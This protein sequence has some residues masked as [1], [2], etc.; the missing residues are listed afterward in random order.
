MITDENA[1]EITGALCSYLTAAFCK[2]ATV[3][4]VEYGLPT[5]Y[6][7]HDGEIVTLSIK[8]PKKASAEA[9]VDTLKSSS[10]TSSTPAIDSLMAVLDDQPSLVAVDVSSE[11]IVGTCANGMKD[12]GEDDIDCGSPLTSSCGPCGARKKCFRDDGCKYGVCNGVA[13]DDNAATCEKDPQL[14]CFD[15][16]FPCGVCC[17]TGMNSYGDPCW[18]DT[19]TA[20][21]CCAVAGPQTGGICAAAPTRSAVAAPTVPA[22]SNEATTPTPVT[23]SANTNA[24]SVRLPWIDGVDTVKKCST[25]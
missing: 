6:G 21:K 2:S 13:V 4:A 24:P 15:D 10:S 23:K 18:D 14:Q 9:V 7:I 12:A 8:L 17:S 11:T 5:S 1:N 22:S 3:H 25:L 16:D 20:A 19:Y